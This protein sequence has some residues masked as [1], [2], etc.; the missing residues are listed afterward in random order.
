VVVLSCGPPFVWIRMMSN[1]RAASMPRTMRATAITGRSSGMS[2]AEQQG[3][4]PC[5][6]ELAASI[7]SPGHVLQPGEEDQRDERGGQP[8]IGQRDRE[9][10][11]LRVARATDVDSEQFVD[12]PEVVD[13]Q[14]PPE[15]PATTGATI[16]GYM[17]DV[18]K[19]VD[20]CP[21]TR[22]AARPP[23]RS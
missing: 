18:R 11:D 1:A 21:G 10:G 12:D 23:G 4:E 9:Q 13:Q 16:R 20:G 14:E 3:G 17:N 8:D 2:D 7:T 5:P 15:Q 6:V 19:T 22:T